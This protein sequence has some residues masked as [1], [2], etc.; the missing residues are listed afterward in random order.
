[1]RAYFFDL[2]VKDKDHT[3]AKVENKMLVQHE[4][5]I[6][7]LLKQILPQ[8]M[9]VGIEE[10]VENQGSSF[11]W[12]EF[13][14]RSTAVQLYSQRLLEIAQIRLLKTSVGKQMPANLYQDYLRV[15]AT[16][17]AFKNWSLFAVLKEYSNVENDKKPE[18]V[19]QTQI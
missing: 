19:S 8:Y 16:I 2:F 17:T 1:M 11:N 13:L 15:V 9:I 5:Q 7:D 10:V 6:Y 14:D 4:H 18:I 12:I 3:F